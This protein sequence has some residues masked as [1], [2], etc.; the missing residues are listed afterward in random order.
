MNAKEKQLA[1]LQ[2]ARNNLADMHLALARITGK[3][4]HHLQQATKYRKEARDAVL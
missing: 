2:R 3:V 1:E 4:K